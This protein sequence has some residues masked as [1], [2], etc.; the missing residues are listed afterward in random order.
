M[1][2]L[3]IVYSMLFFLKVVYVMVGSLRPH[4]FSILIYRSKWALR[5]ACRILGCISRL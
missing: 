3:K 4:N 2:V 1:S 5:S